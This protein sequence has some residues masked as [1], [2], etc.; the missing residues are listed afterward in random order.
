MLQKLDF[1]VK[2]CCYDPIKEATTEIRKWIIREIRNQ[3][4]VTKQ[5]LAQMKDEKKTQNGS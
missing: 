4:A 5:Q 3:Q 2:W 1:V